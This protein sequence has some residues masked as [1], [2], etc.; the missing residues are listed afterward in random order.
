LRVPLSRE[1]RDKRAD[2]ALSVRWA[3]ELSPSPFVGGRR[4]V[5]RVI[6]AARPLDLYCRISGRL[7]HRAVGRHRWPAREDLDRMNESCAAAP[8]HDGDRFEA[9]VDAA[10]RKAQSSIGTN[11]GS[12]LRFESLTRRRRC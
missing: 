2:K 10:L 8:M 6:A 9:N 12:F 1:L 4:A 11:P 7:A 3:C 5:A